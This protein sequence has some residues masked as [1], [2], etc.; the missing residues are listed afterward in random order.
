MCPVGLDLWD[1]SLDGF[2]LVADLAP[3]SNLG[4]HHQL[5]PCREK[6]LVYQLFL[7]ACRRPEVLASSTTLPGQSASLIS[8]LHQH[9]VEFISTWSTSRTKPPAAM[10][11]PADPVH[12][13]LAGAGANTFTRPAGSPALQLHLCR[14][15][16]RPHLDQLLD[17]LLDEHRPPGQ[18]LPAK[19]N[20]LGQVL[21]PATTTFLSVAGRDSWRKA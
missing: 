14:T 16:F 2:L 12:L 19:Q 15:R 6:T 10:P 11:A 3:A 8:Q 18:P 13:S 9:L 7:M 5:P 20:T 21:F 17:Q 1:L 4:G